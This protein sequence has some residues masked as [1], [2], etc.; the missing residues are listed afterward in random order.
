VRETITCQTNFDDLPEFLTVEEI[1]AYLRL[2]R[3]TIYELLRRGEL[4]HVRFGR[5]IRVPK[6]ALAKY[7]SKEGV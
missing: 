6:T 7:L 4:P 1:R 3:S 2:G 5:A